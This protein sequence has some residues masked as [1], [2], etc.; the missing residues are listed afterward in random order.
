MGAFLLVFAVVSL[1]F[2]M[3]RGSNVAWSAPISYAPIAASVVLFAMFLYVETRVAAEPFAPGRIIF[4]GSMFAGYICMFASKFPSVVTD[5][6]KESGYCVVLLST[7]S[8]YTFSFSCLLF[9]QVLTNTGSGSFLSII[10]FTPLFYQA[11]DGNT[12]TASALKIIPAVVASVCGSLF[13]GFMI[14]RT[15]RLY[16]IT[17][18]GYVM[19][20]L[21]AL[22]IF[23]FSGTVSNS[24]L[25]ISVGLVISAFGSG[26][27]I[28]TVLIALI[29]DAAPEDQAVT[30]ACTYLFRQ[31]GAVIGISLSASFIQQ[32]LRKSLKEALGSGK[33]AAKIEKRV[34]RS[35]KYLRKLPLE[36]QQIIRAAYGNAL[37][38]GFALMIAIAVGATIACIFLKE[39]RLSR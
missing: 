19:L 28:T 24:V 22:S 13:G 15:G 6:C 23:L 32:Q 4:K 34:R 18:A 5:T 2:G 7:V 31:L 1:V 3:D 16:W 26:I 39:K 21:G 36:K 8:L 14:K 12:A 17:I 11:V 33:D 9:A 30:T 29:S 27:G 37:R 25:M 20:P 35:L 10:Y 38:H